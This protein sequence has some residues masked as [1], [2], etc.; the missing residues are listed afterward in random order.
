M[1]DFIERVGQSYLERKAFAVPQQLENVAKK[2]FTGG[3]EEEA[4]T[5][6]STGKK[7]T[8]EEEEMER[9][10]GKGSG[11]NA[12]QASPAWAEKEKEIKRLKKELAQ[13]KLESPK[14][15]SGKSTLELT[16]SGISRVSS[17]R[18]ASTSKAAKGDK[19]AKEWATKV[20]GG[21]QL[22]R[23]KKSKSGEK[24]A[25]SSKPAKE[26]NIIEITPTKP[27]TSLSQHSGHSVGATNEH[28]GWSKSEHGSHAG[29][30]VSH[31]AAVSEG[32][33]SMS[34]APYDAYAG[35]AETFRS[36]SPVASEG[37]RRMS[38]ALHS[39]PGNRAES[40]A[41]HPAAASNDA[42]IMSIAPRSEYG[43][44]AESIRSHSA[45]ASED[46]R[47]MPMAPRSEYG[48]HAESIRSHSAAASE[49]KRIM[50]MAPRSEYGG[51]A[52][53][54]RSHSAAASS[55]SGDKRITP[56]APRSEYGGHAESIRSHSAAGSEG[57]RRQSTL[58]H[59]ERGSAPRSIAL[60]PLHEHLPEY[61]EEIAFR[62]PRWESERERDHY[63]VDIEEE[64][65]GGVVKVENSEGKM[66]YEYRV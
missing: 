46:K 66:L 29:S 50:P 28:G 2:H 64:E 42:R 34:I 32:R 48:G 5:K 11:K 60:G 37:S 3:S 59:S 38:I 23:R 54:V 52:D 25:D 44:H 18:K 53:S 62:E 31:S 15:S 6:K 61:G 47:I 10:T 58:S 22:E 27:R 65:E 16:K 13:L 20:V 4:K 43:G 8:D 39:D 17:V 1:E 7:T 24:E 45:A 56:M 57:R 55:S 12:D 14:K 26:A 36:H 49:D 19:E 40:I 41:S 35:S 9:M 21:S 63:S 30:T 33:R 51:H